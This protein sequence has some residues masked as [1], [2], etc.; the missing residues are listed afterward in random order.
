M[1]DTVKTETK[2]NPLLGLE[3]LAP[4]NPGWKAK[5]VPHKT[6]KFPSIPPEAYAQIRRSS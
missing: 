6:T 5:I 1:G 2:Q 4:I 3:A